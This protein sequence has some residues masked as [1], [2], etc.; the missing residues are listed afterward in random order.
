MICFS[1]MLF[2]CVNKKEIFPLH[3]AHFTS[4]ILLALKHHRKFDSRA[5]EKYDALI[6]RLVGFVVLSTIDGYRCSQQ[7][8]KYKIYT[9]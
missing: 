5:A 9:G 2:M 1:F 7:N 4:L 6:V 3:S 8:E